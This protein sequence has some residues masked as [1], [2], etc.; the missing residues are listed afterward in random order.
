MRFPLITTVAMAS[1][2]ALAVS[3]C[4][5]ENR[6]I[7]FDGVVFKTKTKKVD[8]NLADFVAYV[9]PVSASLEGA[10]EAGRYE[11]TKYCISNFGTSQIDW[12]VGPETEASKLII[13]EDT[14]TFQGQCNP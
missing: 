6:N 9:S 2:L 14:L 11:G 13:T 4:V 3:G 5:K 12:T 1:A 7:P 8:D 10:R